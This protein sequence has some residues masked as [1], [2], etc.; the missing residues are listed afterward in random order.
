MYA[1]VYAY[2][3]SLRPMGIASATAI[4]PS[5]QS[6]STKQ[7]N[8]KRT[9]E[10]KNKTNCYHIITYDVIWQVKVEKK[11]KEEV[12]SGAVKILIHLSLPL[13]LPSS[14]WSLLSILLFLVLYPILPL[15]SSVS[16][17]P[18]HPPLFS[19]TLLLLS[20]TS[21]LPTLT[22]PF[23]HSSQSHN[24]TKEFSPLH[25]RRRRKL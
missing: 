4:A 21:S 22:H 24:Q 19:L 11:R 7:Q 10:Q 9:K 5:Y 1:Y 2:L 23:I 14:S 8:S 3:P 20:S 17:H 18:L 25:F 15:Y 16:L 12:R 6:N 13:P